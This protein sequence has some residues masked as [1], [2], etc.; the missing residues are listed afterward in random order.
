MF[1][2]SFVI[3]LRGTLLYLAV[4]SI[5]QNNKHYRFQLQNETKEKRFFLFTVLHCV[6]T[7]ERYNIPK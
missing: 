1:L 4:A 3:W 5:L 2:W 7:V 6:S